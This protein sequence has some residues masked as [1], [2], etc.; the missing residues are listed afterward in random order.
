[1]QN[2]TMQPPPP[3]SSPGAS[4]T[5]GAPMSG[6]AHNIFRRNAPY[7]RPNTPQSGGPATLPPVTDPFGLGRTTQ[8]DGSPSL[9]NAVNGGPQFPSRQDGSQLPWPNDAFGDAQVL[10]PGVPA[11]LGE[12]CEPYGAP[13]PLPPA[14]R[15]GEAG[16]FSPAAPLQGAEAGLGLPPEPSYFHTGLGSENSEMVQARL[17]A[18]PP[19]GQEGGQDPHS[20]PPAPSF[21]LPYQPGSSASSQWVASHGSRPPSVQ[22]YFQPSDPQTQGFGGYCA[23]QPAPVPPHQNQAA[24]SHYQ[25]HHSQPLESHTQFPGAERHDAG[26]PPPFHQ[27]PQLQHN[28]ASPGCARSEDWSPG[29]PREPCQQHPVPLP[30]HQAGCPA[31]HL[32]PPVAS[33]PGTVSMFFKG[34]EVENE[35]TLVPEQQSG[36]CATLGDAFQPSTGPFFSAPQLPDLCTGGVEPRG[37][38]PRP[39]APCGVYSQ[40]GGDPAGTTDYTVPQGGG[41]VMEDEENSEFVQNQEVLPSESDRIPAGFQPVPGLVNPG[42]HSARNVGAGGGPPRTLATPDSAHH[43]LRSDSISSNHSSASHSSGSSLRRSQAQMSTF[44]Q[45]ESGKPPTDTPSRFFEQIDSSPLSR[46]PLH[47]GKEVESAG[48]P[49]YYSQLSQP[50]ALSSPKPTATFQASANSSF[51]PVRSHGHL[52]IKA[53][54][55]DQAKMVME[56][57][58]STVSAV[59]QRHG[60]GPLDISPGNLEQPPDNL[61]NIHVPR[62]HSSLYPGT[63]TPE[64]MAR[65]ALEE[66]HKRPS[67]R[68]SGVW[69]K[70]ESPAA[71]LWAQSELPNFCAG[72]MLA[73]AAPAVPAAA[74]DPAVEVVQPPEDGGKGLN[75]PAPLGN[76]ENPPQGTEDKVPKIQANPSYATLLVPTPAS[77]TPPV[78]LARPLQTSPHLPSPERPLR[79]QGDGQSVAFATPVLLNPDLVTT[80][81]GSVHDQAPL[82]LATDG[83]LNPRQVAEAST[84]DPAAP[85]SPPSSRAP[86]AAVT[87]PASNLHPSADGSK[88]ETQNQVFDQPSS[89]ANCELLDFTLH[90]APPPNQPV[91]GT[92][93]AASLPLGAATQNPTPCHTYTTGLYTND[94]PGFYLQVTTDVQQQ[95]QQPIAAVTGQQALPP[96]PPAHDQSKRL[97]GS[98]PVSG[99]Y[100][101][102]GYGYPGSG[103]PP[104]PAQQQ[105]AAEAP[106]TAPGVLQPPTIHEVMPQHPYPPSQPHPAYGYTYPYMC[107]DYG[108]DPQQPYAVPYPSY[109]P[110]LDPR[111]GQQI[112]YPLMDSRGNHPYYQDDPYRRYGRYGRYDASNV[113]YKEPERE[114]TSRPSSRASQSS[115]RPSSRQ[116]C[117][118]DP[119]SGR[120]GREGYASYYPDYYNGQ[121]QYRDAAQWERY[122][123]A[124]YDPRYRD[125]RDY[126][127][128][129]WYYGAYQARDLYREVYTDRRNGLEDLWQYDPRYDVSFDEGS[130]Q[131]PYTDE[132]DG[133]STQS[134]QSVHSALSSHSVRSR[135]SSFGSRSQ[136]SQI[137]R[138][139]QDLTAEAP[140]Q[141]ANTE[142]T[143]EYAQSAVHPG[144]SDYQYRYPS[145]TGWQ[146][147]EKAPA[148]LRPVT[149]EKFTIP[150]L[151]VRFSP[152]GQLL[153]VLPNLPSEGQPALVELHS[154]EVMLQH[155]PEQEELRRFPGPL[156]KE[157]T[158]KVDVIN[159]AQNKATECLRNDELLDKESANLL[160]ELIVLLCRQNGTVI[161]TDIAELLLRE[162]R[163][164]WLPGKSPNEANLIDFNN[165]LIPRAEDETCT[166]LFTDSFL[167]SNSTESPGKDT[168]RFR[169]LLLFGRKKDAL[170]SA[171]KHGLWGHALL[172]AS[173]MDSRT[174]AKVMT[175]FANSLPINDPLQ[176]VYQLMSGRMP[177]AA[178]CCGDERWGD[179]RPHLAMVLSNLSHGLDLD[180]KTI[181]TMGD[182]LAT[183]GL[184]DASHFCYLMAQIGFGVYTRKA[185]K[186]VLIG[187]NHSWSFLRFASNGAIQ[188]TE[189]YEYAQALGNQVCFL[190]NFQVFKFIYACRLA[191]MG[192]AAQAFHYCEVIARTVLRNP[193]YYSPVFLSQLIQI[194]SQLRFFD[195]QLKERSE[196]ELH[197]EPDWIKHLQQT[198]SQLKDG[199]FVCRSGRATPQPFCSSTP[200]SEYDQVSQ[201]DG[202]TTGPQEEASG[203]DNPLMTSFVPDA[204]LPGMLGVQLMPPAPPHTVLD[205]RP[206]AAPPPQMMM[207]DGSIPMYSPTQAS[208]GFPGQSPNSAFKQPYDPAKGPLSMG[209][210]GPTS[211]PPAEALQTVLEQQ[212]PENIECNSIN[213]QT[214]PKRHS[215]GESGQ[216]DFYDHMAKMQPKV[217]T[218]ERLCLNQA[219]GRRSRSTSQ[220]SLHM[221]YGRRSR[222]TSESSTHSMGRERHPSS[223]NQPQF[224]PQPEIIA[225]TAPETKKEPRRHEP[226]G[227]KTK[228]GWLSWLRPGRKNEA[229][230]PDDKN[231]SSK[232]LPPP[233]SFPMTAPVPALSSTTSPA[234]GGGPPPRN[235]FSMKAGT[236]ARYVDVLN[237]SG[238]RPGGVLLPPVDLFAPLAP[239]PIPTNLFVPLPGEGS[240]PSEGSPAENSQP[241]EETNPE[242]TAQAQIFNQVPNADPSPSEPSSLQFG[243]AASQTLHGGPASGAVQFYNPAQFP[244]PSAGPAASRPGRFVQ[245]KYP[246][247]K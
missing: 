104:P 27:P 121:Y 6:G 60:A 67:S 202:L 62:P 133:H 144:Y 168:E 145:E 159:F 161:G 218:A 154:L 188:R 122:D 22:N 201:S 14:P 200:S 236:K 170:E 66:P 59:G 57:N 209:P 49:L 213:Q 5:A 46:D 117:A 42:L 197:V 199:A 203:V 1:M 102:A 205:S 107:Q 131:D 7:R 80:A 142:Y 81:Q 56:L 132:F 211:G 175:R 79:D 174:H 146:P 172:L 156:V 30:G 192:L 116:G 88:D 63:G 136:Q 246:T 247:L 234:L 15:F 87:T 76:M 229:H 139:Q 37:V 245:R 19:H 149:P 43:P 108:A 113:S 28:F 173:K 48:R 241:V 106:V 228:G 187:S 134:E 35:E 17:Q 179:W 44:I 25:Q 24:S 184:L 69:V 126:D 138:S 227:K 233:P 164:V 196:Q 118:E 239:M 152:G 151:C 61:E 12:R 135:R 182:T 68:V 147:E 4:S 181:T 89:S 225:S 220:S 204:G 130:R 194:S 114:K 128:P 52:A 32:G 191:E 171:M 103:P 137:Y 183:K 97:V 189:A 240:Q 235:R 54:E 16:Q 78:L 92:N 9:Q 3:R 163:S 23:P 124:A 36:I 58:Q 125:Y 47:P 222:T 10:F 212:L 71:T 94:K 119:Y 34:G 11:A 150:H 160:W 29:P 214:S 18:R 167:D 129:Y 217:N 20:F 169:E 13:A 157:E 41:L 230:L 98:V 84:A 165:D 26:R 224:P 112:S 8:T 83:R 40:G 72:I 140:A 64:I 110:S 74:K 162:H 193:V 33:D 86:P 45:Q 176:T 53:V 232:P 153:K 219:P 93:P 85:T 75:Y 95:Q 238:S 105:L 70:S 120:G 90:R 223:I 242:G 111:V 65:P 208:P 231:K 155:M 21:P 166:S 31:P 221:P 226:E 143:Y 39:P 127:V 195:P 96:P 115:N 207:M 109:P 180:R 101:P 206:M 185:T 51:E 215:F 177:A 77:P 243:E 91:A 148:P 100:P 186:L 210:L 50:P 82:N 198:E 178:T 190:P 244:Q 73:P 158:H 2:P 141:V 216:Q 99:Q 55:V 237:P 123:P 38:G